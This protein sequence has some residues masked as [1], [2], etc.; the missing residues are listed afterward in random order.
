MC[1]HPLALVLSYLVLA[2]E[3]MPE[4]PVVPESCATLTP[5]HMNTSPQGDNT[6]PTSISISGL[7]GAYIPGAG[8]AL[9]GKFAWQ[10]NSK[11]CRDLS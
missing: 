7:G 3:S 6:L 4:G 2:S 5:R 8:A 10:G 1:F 9:T 11:I